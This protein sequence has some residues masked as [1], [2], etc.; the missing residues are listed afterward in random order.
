MRKEG[1]Q[2]GNQTR[3]QLCNC[4]ENFN[5]KL[6][7]HLCQSACPSEGP[8]WELW[9]WHLTTEAPCSS[10]CLQRHA[11]FLPDRRA[12]AELRSLKL[13]ASILPVHKEEPPEL[14]AASDGGGF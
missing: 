8:K 9:P 3:S 12:M 2:G 4:L 5:R 1:S 14:L 6:I 11:D 7:F 13:R 10:L